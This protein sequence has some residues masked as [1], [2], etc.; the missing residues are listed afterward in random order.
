[1]TI[2]NFAHAHYICDFEQQFPRGYSSSS[3]ATR[4]KM[5]S[6]AFHVKKGLFFG[7]NLSS[8]IKGDEV[9]P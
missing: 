2:G 4:V 6:S 9:T 3:L 7:P 1:M 5:L 8:K